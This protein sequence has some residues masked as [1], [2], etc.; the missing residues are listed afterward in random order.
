MKLLFNKTDYHGQWF[1]DDE[2]PENFTSK[3]PLNT[4]YIFDE[5]LNDWILKPVIE[6]E[7]ISE[8]EIKQ[9]EKQN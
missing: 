3:V 9:E 2:A 7:P 6:P 8:P 1:K 5:N 4:G